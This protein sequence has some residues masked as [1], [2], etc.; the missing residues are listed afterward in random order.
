[1]R[2]R[3]VFYILEMLKNSSSTTLRRQGVV[4]SDNDSNTVLEVY[5]QWFALL[6]DLEYLHPDSIMT[7]GRR[8][9]LDITRADVLEVNN[10]MAECARLIKVQRRKGFK[11]LCSVISTHLYPLIKDDVFKMTD[12]GVI[13]AKRLMQVFCYTSRLSLLDIDLTQQMLQSYL[14]VELKID[15]QYPENICRTLNRIVRRWFGPFGPDEI[16]P[17]HGPGGIA[18]EGRCPL[19]VKYRLLRHDALLRYCFG[20]PWWV[21]E[22]FLKEPL[23]RVSRT[24]FVPKSYKTFRTISMEPATLQYF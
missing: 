9:W 5:Q 12:S 18:E 7:T 24:I 21:M 16:T 3:Q 17:H 2:P 14:E 6:I 10:A 13:A 20:D 15:D 8:L 23:H 22:P 19:Q 11:A 4:L 1:M